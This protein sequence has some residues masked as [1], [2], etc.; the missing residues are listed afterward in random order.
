MFMFIVYTQSA[1]CNSE[2]EKKFNAW[3]MGKAVNHAKWT[4]TGGRVEATKQNTDAEAAFQSS[5]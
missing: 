2:T 4:S 1:D 3:S 5:D